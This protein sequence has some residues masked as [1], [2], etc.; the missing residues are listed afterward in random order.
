[1]SIQNTLRQYIDILNEHAAQPKELIVHNSGYHAPKEKKTVYAG[2]LK[3]GPR[4]Q[5]QLWFAF[6]TGEPA[7]YCADWTIA[8]RVADMD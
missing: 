1:M 3:M 5:P 4:G 8:G 6:R 7:E 2:G